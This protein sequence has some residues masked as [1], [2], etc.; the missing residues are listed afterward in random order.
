MRVPPHRPTVSTATD[1]IATATA[2]TECSGADGRLIDDGK[3]IKTKQK[4]SI[5]RK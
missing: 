4:K 1:A 3:K 5:K 2:A